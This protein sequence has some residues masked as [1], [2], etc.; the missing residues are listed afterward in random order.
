MIGSDCLGSFLHFSIFSDI[1][2]RDQKVATSVINHV[3]KENKCL[4]MF[5]I[6][7]LKK[8]IFLIILTWY[9]TSCIEEEFSLSCPTKILSVSVGIPKL[10]LSI[11]IKNKTFTYMFPLAGQTAVPKR[12]NFIV[13]TY[14]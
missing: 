2:S 4:K 10:L 6:F 14:G 13:N 8:R 11:Y 3:R 12:L 5:P 1:F 9:A 7:I